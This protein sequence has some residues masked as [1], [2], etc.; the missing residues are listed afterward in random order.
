MRT[1]RKRKPIK[2]VGSRSHPTQGAR[3]L[4]LLC[5]HVW[6]VIEGGLLWGH[7][8][9]GASSSPCVRGAGGFA[10]VQGRRVQWQVVVGLEVPVEEGWLD[11]VNAPRLWW[12]RTPKTLGGGHRGHPTVCRPLTAW[13]TAGP[14]GRRSQSP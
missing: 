6:C 9:P 5:T 13:L 14:L 4:G 1:E 10:E 3:K 2:A 8:L 11:A 12:P 7:W